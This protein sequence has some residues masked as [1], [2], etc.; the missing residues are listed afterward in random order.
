MNH[1]IFVLTCRDLKRT[2][3]LRTF[4]IWIA[5]AAIAV[6]FFF[7][8]NGYVELV[9]HNHVEF[10]AIFLPQIIFGA[11]AV[12]SVY[13][14]LV[15]ADREHNV[16]DCILC[17]GVT[18]GQVFRAKLI[19]I[20]VN[21]LLLSFIYLIPITV[22]IATLSDVNMALTVLKYLLPLWGYIMVFA[23]MGVMISVLARSS[24][25]AMIWSMASGL[26][27]MPRFFV[28]IVEGIGNAL[29]LSKKVIDEISLISPGIMM[30]TLSKPENTESWMIASMGFT[31]AV[32]VMITIAYFTFENQD[33]YNYGD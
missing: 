6:F 15:A 21:S 12:M 27:L 33:E 18:K 9:E 16:L 11:W 28:M 3:S 31:I 22:I 2:L 23:A 25:A 20:V 10:M 4:V 13:F 14:D 19:T 5:L 32:V 8:S 29:K 7:T 26:I 30:E 17:S 1:I 24:K